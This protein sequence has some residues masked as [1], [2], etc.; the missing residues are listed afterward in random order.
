MSV[1]AQLYSSLDELHVLPTYI[2]VVHFMDRDGH[3][4][5]PVIHYNYVC[6]YVYTYYTVYCTLHHIFT[7]HHITYL[8]IVRTSDHV[9]GCACVYCVHAPHHVHVFMAVKVSS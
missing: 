4:P 5:H 8:C 1:R 2:D 6:M 3:L 7:V 9:R